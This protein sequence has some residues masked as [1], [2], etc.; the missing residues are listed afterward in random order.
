MRIARP[1]DVILTAGMNFMDFGG[2]QIVYTASRE[3]SYENVDV[4]MCI[5]W[6]NDGQLVP[7]AYDLNL[8]ADGYVIGSTSFALK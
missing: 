3:V 8:Y 7:G 5:Y 2:E 1:D 4:D 6:Q